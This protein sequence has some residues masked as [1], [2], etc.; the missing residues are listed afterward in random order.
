MHHRAYL[1][2]SN[3]SQLFTG[4]ARDVYFGKSEGEF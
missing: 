1:H 2:A 3:H 4:E